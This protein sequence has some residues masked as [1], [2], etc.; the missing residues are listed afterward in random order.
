VTRAPA[1]PS[2][3]DDYR[4]N[5]F[6]L[7]RL[8]AALQ[9]ACVHIVS[10]FKPPGLAVA[11]LDAG[12]RLFPG[13]PMFFLISGVLVSR[14]YERS[15]SIRDYYR[16]R[17][18][19]IFPALWVCLVVSIGVVV[20]QIHAPGVV[21]TVSSGDWIVWWAAQM[22]L[23]Q[24]YSPH[25]LHGLRLNGSL[26]TIPVELEFY[27]LLPVLYG[28]FRLRER[29]GNWPL[30]GVLA[31]SVAIH[32]VF[33]RT[34]PDSL[35]AQ[36]GFVLDTLAPYLW[37]FL[38]G[39]LIQRNWNM[40]RGWFAGRAH[41]WLLGYVLAGTI[42][43][44]LFH[45]G[46]GSNNISPGF[47]VPLAGVVMSCAMSARALADRILAHNDISYGTYIYHMPVVAVMLQLG[48]PRNIAL[49]AVAV[50]V[51]AGLGALSWICVERPFLR[52]KRGALRSVPAASAHGVG[53]LAAGR[54]RGPA[55]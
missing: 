40:L 31:G 18:L 11:M 50:G 48:A 22:S 29:R 13:V 6:D 38:T 54:I 25:F 2:L 42:C 19:R 12:L 35:P 30:L 15:G 21:D 8:F 24:Q 14:S 53:L 3:D 44:E 52:Q 4:T 37:M 43:R 39:V 34:E 10:N 55:G 7:I 33:I 20:L 28:L 51:S 26:W 46:V 36:Y 5:N 32:W 27:L 17:C 1:Q 23:F 9:V 47:L 49:A 16:N 45:I 41:W